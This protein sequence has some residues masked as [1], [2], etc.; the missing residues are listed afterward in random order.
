MANTAKKV[1]HGAYVPCA[2]GLVAEA[3]PAAML[4]ARVVLGGLALCMSAWLLAGCATPG[5]A[6]NASGTGARTDLVTESDEPEARRRARIRMELASGY[7]SE[8]KATIA[9]D[10]LK[11]ALVIDPTFPDAYNL[12]GL[13]YMR[14]NDVRLAE[15]SFRRALA[16]NPRDAN[17]AHNFGW[18]L[19]QQNRYPESFAA[20][21]QALAVPLY[22][23]QAK[24]YMT[25]GLCQDAAG[26]KPEA[27]RSLLHS[28]EIDAA[29]P[30][31]GFNLANL[32]YQRSDFNRSQF[33]IRRINNS[34][35]ANAETLWLGIKVERRMQNTEAVQQL[36]DQLRRRY[37][38]ARELAAY[39]RGAFNE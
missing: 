9:L 13:I 27:E 30:I 32:M 18:M 16:L 23:E 3:S 29:N 7:F 21:N 10:E 19:C 14:L 33:Y 28:Y 35:Y 6:P 15:D 38:K 37:P 17:A 11:Q 20:F 22:N 2:A 24:T 1:P 39:E 31:T 8:G 12:R 5:G 4:N 26:Q 25:L 34:E 36:A